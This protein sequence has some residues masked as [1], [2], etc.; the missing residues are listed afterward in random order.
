VALRRRVGQPLVVV[1]LAFGILITIF[2]SRA[3][4][5][6]GEFCYGTYL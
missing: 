3:L 2:V 1:A 6:N 4:A 5:Y